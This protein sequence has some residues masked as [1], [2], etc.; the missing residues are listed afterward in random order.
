MTGRGGDGS[1]AIG[2]ARRIPPA[3][4]RLPRGR[5][6]VADRAAQSR[7]RI[8]HRSGNAGRKRVDR[9]YSTPLEPPVPRFVPIV[10]TFVPFVAGAA[11]MRSSAF[12]FYNLVGAAAWVGLCVG[13]GL[14]FANVPIIK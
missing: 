4:D 14:L 8:S 2:V 12:G 7:E 5:G 13:A 3:P 1:A 9:R 10:R 6:S 11:G